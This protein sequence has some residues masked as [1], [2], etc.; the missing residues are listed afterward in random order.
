MKLII[1]LIAILLPVVVRSQGPEVKPLAIGDVVPDI[2]ITNLYNYPVSSVRLSDLRGRLVILDFW[3]TWCGSCIH[4]LPEM[5]RLQKEFGDKLMVILVNPFSHDSVKKVQAFFAKRKAATGMDVT[6]PY[7]LQQDSLQAYFPFRTIPHF[8]WIA[9]NGKI[10]AITSQTEVT[11]KNV[12]N[13]IKENV[14]G[15]HYKKDLVD[16]SADIPLFVNG[17]GGNGNDFVYRS[18]FTKY[19]EGI[20]Y[21]S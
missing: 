14:Q 8:I 5:H 16:F 12:S 18:L 1:G 4:C 19:I 2:T 20:G 15:L 21:G 3:S 11:A 7:S 13:A 9:Q 17:N 6:L 10:I